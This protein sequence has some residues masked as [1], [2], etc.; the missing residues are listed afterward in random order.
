MKNVKS[1]VIIC[2]MLISSGVLLAQKKSDIKVIGTWVFTAQDA[3]VEYSTG[4]L[5]ISQE[6]KELKGE[7]IFGEQYKVPLQEVKLVD[8]VL[9]FKAYIDGEPIE[10]KNEIIKD[11][12]KGEVSTSDGTLEISAKRKTK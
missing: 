1:I 7:I 11:E 4:D 3:P 9:T 12:M 2:L 8:N 6:G 5:V 10:V